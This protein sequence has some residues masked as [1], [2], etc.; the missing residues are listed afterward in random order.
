MIKKVKQISDK[1]VFSELYPRKGI[2]FLFRFY[3][4]QIDDW[5]WQEKWTVQRS[6]ILQYQL[7]WFITYSSSLPPFN[8]FYK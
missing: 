6:A 2:S 7:L 3:I 4:P 5:K 1:S 8:S